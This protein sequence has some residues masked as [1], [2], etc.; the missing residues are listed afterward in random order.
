MAR[1]KLSWGWQTTLR[2][3][4]H[5]GEG[6]IDE[7]AFTTLVGEADVGFSNFAK[8]ALDQM[9][10]TNAGYYE[11]HPDDRS[12]IRITTKGKDALEHGGL[13]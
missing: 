10:F 11:R 5:Y 9:F 2:A 3:L 1:R 4:D 6:G 13:L 12:K 7:H 8:D